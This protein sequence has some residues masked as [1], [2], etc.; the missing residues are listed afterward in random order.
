RGIGELN[1][2][3]GAGVPG[4]H[5][6]PE[7]LVARQRG[8][9]R[10]NALVLVRGNVIAERIPRHRLARKDDGI[11]LV[12]DRVKA[13]FLTRD[14]A[15]GGPGGLRRCASICLL[16]RSCSRATVTSVASAEPPTKPP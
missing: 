13:H 8:N 14:L 7:R 11:T 15:G 12:I 16:T 2:S 4:I 1:R 9:G 3:D 10:Q 5:P 6:D